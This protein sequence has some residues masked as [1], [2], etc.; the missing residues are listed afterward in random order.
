MGFVYLNAEGEKKHKLVESAGYGAARNGP[1][2]EFLFL[3][4]IFAYQ[5]S[6]IVFPRTPKLLF[7]AF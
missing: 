5:S 3:L 4:I 2:I 6:P 1:L 7:P